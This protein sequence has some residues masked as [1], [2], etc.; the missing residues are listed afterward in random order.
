V[1]QLLRTHAGWLA[2]WVAGHEPW[3]VLAFPPHVARQA[4]EPARIVMRRVLPVRQQGGHRRM[5]NRAGGQGGVG[6]GGAG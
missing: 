3:D 5:G 6:S 1:A 4:E 2:A